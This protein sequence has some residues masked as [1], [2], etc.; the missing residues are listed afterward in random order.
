[1]SSAKWR[2]FCLGPN[3]LIDAMTDIVYKREHSKVDP[4]NLEFLSRTV[5]YIFLFSCIGGFVITPYTLKMMNSSTHSAA[6]MR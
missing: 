1:M 5:E 3:V 2:P 6:Y 4:Q